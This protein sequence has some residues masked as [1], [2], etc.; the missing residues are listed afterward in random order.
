MRFSKSIGA[1]CAR[2]W[3]CARLSQKA[4][5]QRHDS[6]NRKS[7][8]PSHLMRRWLA[9]RVDAPIVLD[10]TCIKRWGILRLLTLFDARKAWLQGPRSFDR[11]L[12]GN[13]DV[14]ASQNIGSNGA[15]TRNAATCRL[16]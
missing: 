10:E 16:R 5:G 3:P 6:K 9:K 2:A 13:W 15:V 8:L 1:L 4:Y 7:A 11:Q 14:F 12:G